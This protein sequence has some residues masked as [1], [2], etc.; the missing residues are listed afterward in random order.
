LEE[1]REDDPRQIGRYTLLGRLG[2]GGM[3]QVFLGRS[4]GGRLVAV[5]VIHPALAGDNGFRVRFTREVEAARRVSGAFTAPLID[6][7]PDARLPW[8]VT[9]YIDGSSLADAIDDQGPLPVVSVLALAAGLAEGISAVH[10]AGVIHRDLKPSNVL[11]AHDGPRLIDFGISQAADFSH[12]TL[13]GTVIGT[14]GFMSPEQA[15][16]RS[17]GPPSDIF[18]LG[19]VL[20]FAATGEGPYGSGPP[21]EVHLRVMNLPP[22]LDNLPAELRPLVTR[23][24]A[25]DPARRPTAGQFLAELIAAHPSAASEVEWPSARIAVVPP[26]SVHLTPPE[27]PHQPAWPPTVTA[28]APSP[29]AKVISPLS[30]QQKSPPAH[31]EPQSQREERPQNRRRSRWIPAALVLAIAGAAAGLAVS[32]PG[33]HGRGGAGPT[34]SR[35]AAG[36]PSLPPPTGLTASDLSPDSVTIAWSGTASGQ[37]PGLYKITMNG[38]DAGSVPGGTTSH[39]QTGLVPGVLYRFS[40]TAVTDGVVSPPSATVAVTA[41]YPAQS[42]D[43][44]TTN[45]TA[46]WWSYGLTANQVGALISQ[47]N[48][49]PTQIRV[50]DPSVPT[51]AVTMVANTGAYASGWW[52]FFGQTASQVDHLLSQDDAEL[53]S[54]DPYQTSAGLRFAII[55][56]PDAGAQAATWW[57]YGKNATTIGQLLRRNDARLIALRPYLQDGHTLF[58]VIMISDTGAGY[59][60]WQ[61]LCGVTLDAINSHLNSDHMRPVALVPD[62][63]GGWDA[64]LVANEGE[65]W[66]WWFGINAQTVQK[67]IANDGTRLIDLSPYYMN[68]KLVFAALELEDTIPK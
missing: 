37:E 44:L 34:A 7:D 18:S 33:E 48:A 59:M 29:K 50:M 38:Q 2:S 1:L 24:T 9:S 64:I 60:P 25:R 23:C 5:K 41:P 46:W 66:Y 28:A 21:D 52:W 61:Y 56:V 15:L 31:Q 3:G 36:H 51:F 19:A 11:L 6:A 68:G 13:M 65:R 55:M 4:P 26:P 10:K 30:G 42:N 63:S 16:G 47:H 62:P 27:T 20:A 53:T 67:N 39:Q 57:Y 8:L 43:Q 32:A 54:I 49:R 40:V 12:V 14:P 58:A 22:R 17:V 45:A 35:P